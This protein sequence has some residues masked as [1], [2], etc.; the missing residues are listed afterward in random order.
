MCGQLVDVLPGQ[1]ATSGGSSD[2]EVNEPT[3]RP[4]GLWSGAAVTIVTPVGK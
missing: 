2:T 3:A 4:T 1:N